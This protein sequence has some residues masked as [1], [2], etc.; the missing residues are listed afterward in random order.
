MLGDLDTT[1]HAIFEG[2]GIETTLSACMALDRPGIATLSASTLGRAPLPVG[3]P[4]VILADR[5]AEAAAERGA[6]LRVAERRRV[7]IATPPEDFKDFNDVLRDRGIDS[8]R[9]ALLGA[10]QIVGRV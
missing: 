5:G 1:A 3:R 4:V 9:S 6:S 8:V 10:Q 7:W 2:E